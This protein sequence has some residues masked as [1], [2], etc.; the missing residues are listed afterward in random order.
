MNNRI[1]IIE[2]NTHFA[3]SMNNYIQNHS[4]DVEAIKIEKDGEEII[5]KIIK[6]KPNI[7]L[8]DLQIPKANGIEI[9][10]KMIKNKINNIDIIIISGEIN[11]LNKIPIVDYSL[12]K[13][14]LVKPVDLE[15]VFK[16]IKY[17]INTN[18]INKKRR[19][20][21]N[22]L[23][24]FSFNKSSIGY[25]YLVEAI[26]MVVQDSSLLSNIEKLVYTKIAKKFNIDNSK[27]VKWSILKLLKSMIRYSKKE[28]VKRYFP[29]TLNP[30]PKIFIKEVSDIVRR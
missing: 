28:I 7:L 27:K 1:M 21:E 17:L 23:S 25:E 13:N 29:Y 22:V 11:L 5:E 19:N 3:M 15:E 20:I 14:V 6:F 30:T 10:E 8:L 16:K 12:I 18:E 26:I 4:N 2:D 9:I 24:E